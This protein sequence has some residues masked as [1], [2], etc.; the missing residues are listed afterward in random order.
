MA[1]V[2]QGSLKGAQGDPAT[3]PVTSV[4]GRTGDVTVTKVDVGL[5]NVDNTADTSKTVASA[6]KLTT[7]RTIN[8]VSFNGTANITVADATKEPAITAGTT[9]QYRRGDKTWQ[10]LNADAVPDGTTNKAYTAAEKTKLAGIAAGADV[11]PSLAAVATTGSYADLSGKPTIPDVSGKA[12]KA[13]TISAGTGLSGGGDLSTNRSLSV[14][15]GS[16]AGTACQGNDTRLS[17]ARPPTAHTHNA[18]DVNAGTLAYARLPV[19]VA[20][21]TVAAGND[22]RIVNAVQSGAS[23]SVVVGTLPGTGVTGVLYVVP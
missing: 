11:T 23:G 16:T 3:N 14:G 13:T 1:W 2:P 5:G 18:S 12:D 17:N 9:A 8:G 10:T 22:S 19:G 15:Y 7:A 4:A 20:A 6:A 21:S